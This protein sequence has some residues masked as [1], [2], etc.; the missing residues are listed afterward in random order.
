M[1]N[2]LGQGALIINHPESLSNPF[3]NAGPAWARW[4]LII[5]ATMATSKFILTKK[6]SFFY[7]SSQYF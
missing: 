3:F 2:Y 4:P 7:I 6:I 1:V 5:L